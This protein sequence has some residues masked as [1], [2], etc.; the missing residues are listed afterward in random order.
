MSKLYPK[1]KNE[2][3]F[4]LILI[5]FGTYSQKAKPFVRL[6][7][8]IHTALGNTGFAALK[9]VVEYKILYYLKPEIEISY[10]LGRLDGVTNYDEI[11]LVISES[12]QKTSAANY[13]FCPKIII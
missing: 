8:Y 2:E 6:S 13:G 9:M 11:G 12:S 4:T 3:Y 1:N 7:G 5:S 10:R